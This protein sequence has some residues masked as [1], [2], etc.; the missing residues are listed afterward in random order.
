[1]I[2]AT[3]L[4]SATASPSLT[5]IAALVPDVGASIG[6]SIFID[7]R[8]MIVSPS[9]TSLPTAFSIFHTVPVMCAH[10]SA[11]IGRIANRGVCVNNCRP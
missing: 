10:T 2:T 1:M 11:M 5:L 4:P 7:S 3:R 6:I 9:C 8:I